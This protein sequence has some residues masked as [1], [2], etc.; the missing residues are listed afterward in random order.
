MT[1]KKNAPF[2]RGGGAWISAAASAALIAGAPLI[3]AVAANAADVDLDDQLSQNPPATADAPEQAQTPGDLLPLP[4]LPVWTAPTQF[5][6]Q[7][8]LL[9]GPKAPGALKDLPQATDPA[10]LLGAPKAPGALADL[11]KVTDPADLLG[12]TPPPAASD[13]PEFTIPVT[14]PGS[15]DEPTEEPTTAP[16]DKPTTAPTEKPTTEPTGKATDKATTKP[17]QSVSPSK[18]GDKGK[19]STGTNRS[20]LAETGAAETAAVAALSVG[21][22]GA[23]AG[24]LVLNRRRQNS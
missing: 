10:E 21:L 12:L 24:V 3:G 1:T 19:G 9:G 5:G 11:P 20:G 13:Q 14:T 17:T 8:E 2:R 4:T 18:D 23:A 7:V 6:D 16:T 22:L 15:T